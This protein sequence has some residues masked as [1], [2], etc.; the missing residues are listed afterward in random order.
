MQR[1]A[2]VGFANTI[3]ANETETETV[4]IVAPKL[5]HTRVLL[6]DVT[7]PTGSASRSLQTNELE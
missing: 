7:D 4:V 1:Q 3:N 2:L 6:A 5:R